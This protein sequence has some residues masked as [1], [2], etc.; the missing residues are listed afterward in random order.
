MSG[1][2]RK[3]VVFTMNE[4]G[5]KRRD[6]VKNAAI[7]FLTIMLILTFFSNTIMN[8]S[9]PEV[10]V[11]YVQSG[12]IT[13][14][15]RGTGY[16]ESDDPYEVMI[17][18]QR[19]VESVLV[20]E[21]DSVEKGDPLILLS[22]KESTELAAAQQAF[23]TAQRSLDDAI[24]RIQL[25]VLKGELSGSAASHIQS[26]SSSSY[27]TYQGQISTLDSQISALQTEIDQLNLE[28]GQLEDYKKWLEEGNGQNF[29]SEKAKVDEARNALIN[30][31]IQ[32][33]YE[34]IEEYQQK[35]DASQKIIGE[36]ERYN[37]VSGGNT[38]SPY[39][40]EEYE[41]AKSDKKVYE[42][43]QKKQEDITKDPAKQQ[44]FKKLQ[45]A[46]KE[47]EDELSEKQNEAD[48]V[49]SV[50]EGITTREN[51]LKQKEPQLTDLQ[52]QRE[53]LLKEIEL[54]ITGGSGIAGA[55]ITDLRKALN[56]ARENLEKVKEKASAATIE[57]P[58]SGTIS[59][60]NVTAG[61]DTTA[62]SAVLTML[63]AG[64]G[65]TMSFSVTMEQARR[66][67]PGT[68]AELTN[69]W[70]Y[71]DVDVTL[72]SIRPDPNNPSQSRLLVFNVTGSVAAGQSLSVSIGDRSANYEMVVPNN[73]IRE[74][75]NG[76]FVLTI[77]SKSSP[78]GT[79]YVATRVDVEVVASD[80]TQSA[81]TGGL[82]AYS[83][84]IT[85]SDIPVSAGQ[86]VRLADN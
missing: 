57:A 7:I 29:S 10:A 24:D 59:K 65:F 41:K 51:Q 21:G 75:S 20:R 33:A 35:I 60:I 39:T 18:E 27:A 66:L 68:K 19:T 61:R 47:A 67:T 23:D 2:S 4:K 36:Y 28:I 46:L 14:R 54:E 55:N 3:G 16:V 86:Q 8:Y 1:R 26:G 15:I 38:L 58:I 50:E 25:A 43:L 64:A 85:T 63:P 52:T 80:D 40:A 49:E 70:W 34:L 76:K 31:D 82:Y 45:D 5:S 74:D 48:S 37:E 9:L 62:G 13:T 84:V 30:S 73:A 81:I 42:D 17:Y 79:R 11:Q 32:K 44:E 77:E 71:D 12:S 53:N 83:Y 56:E 78:L 22:E 6:W 69:A 72:S